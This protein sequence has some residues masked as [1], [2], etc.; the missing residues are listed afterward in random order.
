MRSGNFTSCLVVAVV[1]AITLLILPLGTSAEEI[2][3]HFAGLDLVF[4]GTDI[5]D[6]GGAAA[7]RDT[8]DTADAD[9][10][11]SASFFDGGVLQGTDSADVMAD[12]LIKGADPIPP[13][14]TILSDGNGDAMGIDIFDPSGAGGWN[15]QLNIDQLGV[16]YVPGFALIITGAVTSIEGQDLPFALNIGEPITVVMSSTKF[17]VTQDGQGRV[18]SFTSSGTGSIA[19]VPEP[20]TL[21]GLLMGTLAFAG[22]HW[23]RRKR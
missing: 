5:Y 4:D 6:A 3:I 18:T 14:G 8:S 1:A 10:L 12:V 23:R 21:L 2:E 17:S 20:S 7:Y 13:F 15:L 16:G 11:S 9:A 19:G 22:C